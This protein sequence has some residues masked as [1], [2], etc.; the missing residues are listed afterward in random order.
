MTAADGDPAS[1]RIRFLPAPL[2]AGLLLVAVLLP[3]FELPRLVLD[4]AP[5]TY[6]PPESEAVALERQ[7]RE[8]FP[9]D[10]VLV[11]LFAGDDLFGAPFL[12]RY[13]RLARSLRGASRV[14]RVIGL[15]TTDH[16]EGDRAGLR[17]SPLVDPRRLE[18]ATAAQRRQRVLADRFAPGAL[19]GPEGER[20]V[21]VARPH[22]LEGSRARTAL[23]STARR[24]VAEAGLDGRL[25][26]MSGPIAL[27]AA[28]YRAMIRDLRLF[29]P[30]S[31]G[32][33]MAVMGF[34]FRRFLA[35]GVA[36]AGIAAAGGLPVLLL[37]LWGRPFTLIHAMLGPL[38]AALTVALLVHLFNALVQAERRGR[39]GPD[40]VRAAVAGIRRPA[41]YTALTTA[42]GL[43]SL[44]LSPIQPVQSFGIVA[45]AGALAVYPLVLGLLAPIVARW[46][47]GRWPASHPS[48]RFLD[49]AA[50]GLGRLGLRRAPWVLGAALAGGLALAPVLGQVTAETDLYR[51]FPRDHPL[52]QTTRQVEAR[53]AGVTPL[54]V[55]LTGPSRDSL[56]APSRLE[57]VRRFADWAEGL[58]E[59]DRAEGM[60]ALVEEM[61]WAMHGEDGTYRR[62]PDRRALVAQYLFVYDG[63]ELGDLVDSERQRTR[64]LL[65]L[66]VHGANAIQ[67]VMDR[68]RRY[69]SRHPPADLEW[70]L[71]GTGRLFAE[72]ED[73]LIRGQVRGLMVALALIGLLLMAVWG[74]PRAALV[75]MVPNVAPVAA[76]F[77]L[78]GMTGIPLDMA[79]A[80][81][82]GVVVGVAVDDTIHLYDGFLRRRARGLSVGH[83]FGRS[84]RQA[85]RAL[86]A[87]TLV[88]AGQFLVLSFSGFQPVAAFGLLAAAGVAAALVFDLVVLPPLAVA[89]ERASPAP[90]PVEEPA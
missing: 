89:R 57:A 26:G 90:R 63:R 30:L 66:N 19:V 36:A 27:D 51:F 60:A 28:Q 5:E 83:A 87:T 40:R 54:E 68:I 75:G 13:H 7:V 41:R 23:V 64:V 81:I 46:D 2:A 15:T 67:K 29:L 33:G 3:L 6:F 31:I 42:V 61:N 12:E 16:I 85:G 71:A 37:S 53:I 21:M 82:A 69:L 43:G 78:L 45:A 74:S 73:L 76:V 24:A 58:P 22:D 14:E 70:R 4:N 8:I 72:Q 47:R 10:Q 44:G 55:V 48:G 52:L 1:P 56:L 77:G 86:I 80:L 65:S 18:T 34:L 84:F 88:L 20:V 39:K 38:L 50:S 59:V 9:E 79:T 62:I 17:V 11:L 35:V 49:A 32:L 25:V